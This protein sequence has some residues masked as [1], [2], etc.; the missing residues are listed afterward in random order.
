MTTTRP[1][2]TCLDPGTYLY[3]GSAKGPGGLHARLGRHLRKA[4]NPRWHIDDLLNH[5]SNLIGLWYDT[6]SECELVAHLIKTGDVTI[7][8]PGFGSSD[9]RT[10]DSHLL[11]I[12]A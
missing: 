6:L 12:I 11:R 7:P 10:C 5:G 2:L 3:A 8:C 4:K 1:R 9:C